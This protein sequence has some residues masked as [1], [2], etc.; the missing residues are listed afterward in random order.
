MDQT[1]I[2]PFLTKGHTF[3]EVAEWLPCHPD[4]L[5]DEVAAGRL[6]A[7]RLSARCVRILPGDLRAWLEAAATIKQEVNV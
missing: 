6:K 4:F 7:R 5:R 2:D 1:Y 3:Q